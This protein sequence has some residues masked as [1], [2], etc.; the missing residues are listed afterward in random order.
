MNKS[1]RTLT[2][3]RIN[4]AMKKAVDLYKIDHKISMSDLIE[5][6]LRSYFNVHKCYKCN[7]PYL[8]DGDLE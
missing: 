8:K 5:N 6:A 2:T 3:L 1:D 4:P 7:G